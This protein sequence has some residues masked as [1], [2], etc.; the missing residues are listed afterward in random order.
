MER[1][2]FLFLLILLAGTEA[3]A[4]DITFY[5]NIAPI[6]Y[7]HCTSCH[8]PGENTPFSLISYIDVAKR[9]DFIWQVINSRY[10]PPWKADTSYR[11]FCHERVL[12]DREKQLIRQWIDAGKPAGE[13]DSVI[14]KRFLTKFINHTMYDRPPDLTIHMAYPYEIKGDNRERFVFVKIPFETDTSGNVEAIEFTANNLRY[15]H[16]VNYAIY[17]AVEGVDIH[18]GGEPATLDEDGPQA[19]Q[20][21]EPYLKGNTQMIYYGGWIPGTTYTYF[22]RD[23]GFILPRKGVVIL[24]FH[25]GPSP[26]DTI[27]TASL[28]FF[29]KKTPIQRKIETISIGSGGIG[30]IMPPL[31][32]LPNQIDTFEVTAQTTKDIS[33]LYVWPHMHLLGKSFKAFAVTPAQDT[34]PLIY[35][36][37]WDFSWQDLYRFT[38]L[39]YLPKGST[40]HVIGVYDNTDQNPRNPFHPPQMIFGDNNELM[41][42]TDE[43][44]TLILLYV[45]YQPHD[46]QLS[47]CDE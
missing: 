31:L 18:E 7:T 4:Q 33:L 46:E 30:N 42:T 1:H 47:I 41:K 29:F 32:I 28:H 43:M 20:Q 38:H 19:F 16:H 2:L 45:D 22:P 23:I 37:H 9:A 8:H 5:K 36:P 34:I 14:E 40:V 11:H 10:M 27:I 3:Y 25:F 6:I 17:P 12:T 44:L 13:S 21:F 24:T 26:V 35:I 39:V 15:I